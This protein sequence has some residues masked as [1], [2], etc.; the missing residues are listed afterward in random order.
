MPGSRELFAASALL[1]GAGSRS[2]ELL[3][4][5]PRISCHYLGAITVGTLSSA[6]AAC[7]LQRLVKQGR[8]GFALLRLH[9][10]ASKQQA[11]VVTSALSFARG[12]FCE[13]LPRLQIQLSKVAKL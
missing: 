11:A 1:D 5:E 2:L 4:V 12:S 13:A 7:T 10:N 8:Q 3:L 6:H 9:K